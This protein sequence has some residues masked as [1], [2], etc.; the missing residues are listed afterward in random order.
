M[1]TARFSAARTPQLVLIVHDDAH[2][3]EALAI[4]LD[5][6]GA[7]AIQVNQTI[8]ALMV[9]RGA[10]ALTAVL[11][12]CS[13]ELV[14]NQTLLSWVAE[15]RPGL[16]LIAVCSAPEHAHGH[17]PSGCQLLSPPFTALDLRRAL[18]EARLTAYERRA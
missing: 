1:A 14:R 17:L 12:R 13:P 6:I 4:A 18:L 16:A 10:P 5:L 9:I 15:H 11:S 3:A 2:V 7:T 8:E